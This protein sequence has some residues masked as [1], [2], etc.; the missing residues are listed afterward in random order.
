VL[1]F[2]RFEAELG[3]APYLVASTDF[4]H[5]EDPALTRLTGVVQRS[6]RRDEQTTFF[7]GAQLPTL[8]LDYSPAQVDHFLHELTDPGTL[9]NL[10]AGIDG[11]QHR[12]VDLDGEGL[13]GIVVESAGTWYFRRGLGDGRFGAMAALPSRPTLLGSLGSGQGTQ[14]LDIDGDGRKELVSFGPPT[15]GFFRRTTEE[16]WGR[17]QAFLSV[18]NINWTDPRLQ[19]IDLSGDGFADLLLDRG[20]RF[21][22]YRSKGAE[23]F[24]APRTVPNPRDQHSKPTVLSSSPTTSIQFA[25]MTG[26]GLADLVRIR[27]GQ[28]AYWA[29]LGRG[30]FGPMIRM[31]GLSSF[32]VGTVFHPSRLRLVDVDG[33]GTTDIIYL[34]DRGAVLYRNL[35][36]NAFAE[37]EELRRFPGVRSVDWAE[38]VDLKGTGTACLAWS[39]SLSSGRGGVLRYIDLM[40]G[41]KPHLLVGSRNNMGAETK[42]SY[43]PSTKFYLADKAA[44]KPWLTKLPFPVQVVERVESIDHV[45]RQRFVSRTAYHHGYFDGQEREFRG[46]GLVETWDTESFEEFGSDGLFSLEQFDNVVEER[47]HQPPVHTKTWFHTGAYLGRKKLSTLFAQEYWQGDAQAPSLPD[48]RLQPGLT[49]AESRE[50]VRALAG[51]TL[52]SEVFSLDGSE[53]E[54]KPYSVSEATFE[55]RQVQAPGPNRHG[56][57]LALG[58]ESLSLHYERDAEDPRVSH[59]FSLEVDAYGTPLRAASVVY[60]RRSFSLPE[61]G[62]LY[63]TLSESEVAHLDGLDDSLRLAVPLESRG[64]ELHGPAAPANAGVFAW[65]AMRDA[66]DLAAP[67]NF[68]TTPTGTEEKRLL[69][70]SRARYLADDLSAPLAYGSVESKALTY[71]QETMVMTDAQRTSVFGS[72]TGAPTNTELQTEGGYLL[73]DAAWWMRSGHP[74]YSPAKFFQVTSVTDPYNNTYTTTY[75]AHAL[76]TVSSADPL[77]NTTTVEHDYR[78]LAPWQLTTPNG[79]RTQAAFDILGF[80]EKTAIMGKTGDS[81]GD[82]LLAPTSTFEYDLFEWQT[83]GA[84]NWAKSRVRETHADPNTAWLEQRTYFSGG[85]GALMVKAQTRPGLAP[86]RDAGGALILDNEGEPVLADTSPNLRWVGN[87]RTILDNKG[88]VLKAYEPYFSSTP[89]YEDE[90][91]L[92]EQGVTALNHYDPLGRLTQTDFPNGTFSR[93][94]FSPWTQTSWDVNDTVLDSPW[95]AERISYQGADVDLLAEKRAAQLAAKHAN[96]PSVVHLDTLGRPFLSIAHNRDTNNQDEFSQT[97]TVLDI[98]GHALDIIDARGNSAETRTYGMLGQSLKVSSIDA[99]DR[100]QLHNALGQPMRSWDSRDQRFSTSYDALRRPLDKLVSVSGGPL[101]LLSRVVYGEQLPTPQATNH[102]G[103]VYRAYDGAGVATTLAFDFKGQAVQEQRQLVASTSAQPDWSTL[104][105]HATIQT[106]SAAAA[107]LLST[108][109]FSASNQRDALGRVLTAVSPDGSLVSYTYDPGGGLQTVELDHKAAG[110]TNTVVG[111]ITY[112]AKGQRTSVVYGPANAPTTTTTYTHDPLTYRLTRLRTLRHSDDAP[113]QSLHYHYDPAGNVTDA[114]DTAQQTVYFQNTV[115]EPANGYEY[116]ALYRLIEATGREHSSQ[117]TSQR[118]HTQLPIGPQPMTSDP[119]AMRRYTQRYTYDAVGNIQTTQHIPSSGT[120]W[121]RHGEYAQDGNRLLTTSAPGDPQSGPYS[122]AYTYDAHGSM[123]TMP[124]LAAMDWGHADQLEHVTAGTQD[125]YFQYAGGSRSRKFTQ[126]PGSTTEERVYLGNFEVY[127]KRVAGTLELERETLHISDGTGRICM[128]ETKTVDA[129]TPVAV[130]A[131]W[132][133]QLG[134]H[135]GS[136]TTEVTNTGA[137]ISHEEYHPYGTSA[138]RAVDA[139][140]DLSPKR[141]RYTGMER[142]EET[143]LAFHSARYLAPWLGRWTAADPIGLGDGINRYAYARGRP[144]SGRDLTGN[145]FLEGSLTLINNKREQSPA[146]S[147]P[148]EATSSSPDV[149]EASAGP[150]PVSEAPAPTNSESATFWG[151]AKTALSIATVPHQI[152]AGQ[153]AGVGEASLEIATALPTLAYGLATDPGGVADGFVERYQTEGALGFTPWPKFRDGVRGIVQADSFFGAGRSWG[154]AAVAT[155]EASGIVLGVGATASRLGRSIRAKSAS[156]ASETL[157]DITQLGS[158]QPSLG[159]T[160]GALPTAEAGG[161]AARE[162]PTIAKGSNREML[163]QAVRHLKGMGGSAADKAKVFEGMA[164]QINK[165]SGGSW[166]A[167]WA[168]GADGAHIFAGEFGEALVVSPT[169]ALFRGNVTNIGSE[170][171]VGAGGKLQ[172]L[173]SALKGL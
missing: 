139:S 134:N 112:D 8:E 150:S 36:G 65:A 157:S 13:P 58:R 147:T 72:L 142:D 97:K 122:H 155:A 136:A 172:P 159:P 156:A 162:V 74:T 173:Y 11:H 102:R 137:I 7:E 63:V 35:C 83:T 25:D 170:F 95:Y 121:T 31:R 27:N 28:V 67:I 53:D 50:A 1:M 46:F 59:E 100:W 103:R 108:E 4:V 123:T 66:A 101:K 167:A 61:Q 21:V 37:G 153:V 5:D 34:G 146:P 127:R 62:A 79:N 49:G 145:G 91:E 110:T 130:P 17:F 149:A 104:L 12:L 80:V 163:G 129:G 128:V 154:H 14:L 92:V 87:G 171:A 90:A 109:T 57:Y 60:P 47:L 138:Y 76:L 132:R 77:G 117:G 23:G 169:G 84:P 39:T 19:M 26:D 42:V 125:L 164:A 20:D 165:L 141:Y 161:A 85:G 119:S 24:E 44:G 116:D 38:V 30:R 120:G 22:W 107:P 71:D 111:D 115:V 52:R 48:A 148:S 6:Y 70:R 133:Y 32:D 96:T 99:G 55:V 135:L 68:E 106:M 114:R 143:G 40:G 93:V 78:L 15:P 41:Q 2:H 152:V 69:S 54:D 56:V 113:L 82:T 94:E 33:S 3:P 140:I 118:G 124:H 158:E 86:Q 151:H 166:S 75:D 73:S 43:V 29:N 131:V 9:R 144:T 126:S 105:P 10:P 89:E 98:Q 168:A 45:S 88:Q 160:P 51:S 81:D 64:Y 18:P 16:G